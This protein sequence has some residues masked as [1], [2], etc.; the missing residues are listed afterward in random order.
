ML[1]NIGTFRKFSVSIELSN[2][3]KKCANCLI[4]KGTLRELHVDI[5][6]VHFIEHLK[7]SAS[8]LARI[9]VTSPNVSK[10][11]SSSFDVPDFCDQFLKTL[12]RLKQKYLIIGKLAIS[13]EITKCFNWTPLIRT[14]KLTFIGPLSEYFID[15]I[16][17]NFDAKL[18]QVLEFDGVLPSSMYFV[19]KIFGSTLRHLAIKSYEH[20]LDRREPQTLNIYR[21]LSSTQKLETFEFSI[22][23]RL[24]SKTNHGI[25][26]KSFENMTKFKVIHNAKLFIFNLEKYLRRWKS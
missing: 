1:K 9:A 11:D 25:Q 19:L 17:Y 6:N 24:E 22:P 23:L 5:G 13:E 10:V 7:Q 16:H 4:N 21:V 18:V 14:I 3:N 15:Y 2:F 12:S 20:S 26:V 8:L